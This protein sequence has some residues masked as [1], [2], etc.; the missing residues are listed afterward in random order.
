[1]KRI[2]LF[3]AALA[4]GLCL[5]A[6]SSIDSKIADYEKACESGNLFKAASIA[7]DIEKQKDKLTEEQLARYMAA[8]AAIG[9]KT[10]KAVENAAEKLGDL[11]GEEKE[12]KED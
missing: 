1:M 7:I 4:M 11:F 10:E 3:V 12:D 8:S 2:T 9:A 6:C 5:A